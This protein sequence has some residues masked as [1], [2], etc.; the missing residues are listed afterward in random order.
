MQPIFTPNNSNNSA[1][2]RRPKAWLWPVICALM[3]LSTA[4]LPG[5]EVRSADV[6][7][8]SGGFDL[9]I[10]M[11]IAFWMCAFIIAIIWTIRNI[12]FF[13]FVNILRNLPAIR[14]LALFFC[15]STMSV[16][17]SVSYKLTFFRAIQLFIMMILVVWLVRTM[18]DSRYILNGLYWAMAVLVVLSIIGFVFWPDSQ[19]ID[20]GEGWIRL[21]PPFYSS[22]VVGEAMA[23]VIIGFLCRVMSVKGHLKKLL[24]GALIISFAIV[25]GTRSRTA[26]III[27][28]AFCAIAVAKKAGFLLILTSVFLGLLIS[29][30]IGLNFLIFAN[31]GNDLQDILTMNNRT[32]IWVETIAIALEKPLLGR[33]YIAGNRDVLQEQI[34][35]SGMGIGGAQAHNAVLAALTDTGVMGAFFVIAFYLEIMVIVFKGI[36][37]TR[38]TKTDFWLQ[39]EIYSIGFAIVVQG[40][41]ACGIAA[42]MNPPSILAIL[43]AF[44]IVFKIKYPILEI[45][46]PRLTLYQMK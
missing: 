32:K 35:R 16:F 39:M 13:E 42:Q 24:W 22:G 5:R 41:P 19:Q 4:T 33:G 23:I 34:F 10:K 18:S 26:F 12:S 17:W 7:Y 45:N 29:L 31:R 25:I 6:I 15:I 36:S 43:A 21:G 20:T 28:F 3:V 8:D 2:K 9:N 30:G 1:T 14:W 11:E 37:V 38:K 27:L 40:I 46:R 44:A